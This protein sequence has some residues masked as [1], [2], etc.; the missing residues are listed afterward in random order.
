MQV[1]HQRR[2][3]IRPLLLLQSVQFSQDCLE[4]LLQHWQIPLGNFPHR[5]Q[6]NTHIIVDQHI[7][8]TSNT[9]PGHL[10]ML[11]AELLGQPLRRLPYNLK[12]SDD[13]ILPVRGREEN[14]STD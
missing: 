1:P 8:Q 11:G 5:L 2:M 14:I 6:V 7:A 10:P 4:L 9:A 3:A 13:C 12:L